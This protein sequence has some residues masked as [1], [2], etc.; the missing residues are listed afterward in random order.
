MNTK[1]VIMINTN[2][3]R[4]YFI[5]YY[6][7]SVMLVFTLFGNIKWLTY[8]KLMTNGTVANAIITT[9]ACSNSQTFSYRFNVGEKSFV[10]SGGDGYGNQPC[11][12][13]KPGDAAMIFYLSSAPET[14]IPG[15]PAARMISEFS[16]IALVAF[17]VPIL[18]LLL[19]F[20]AFKLWRNKKET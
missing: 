10:G 8:L 3:R 13:L 19:F 18:A 15:D 4:I 6:I 17:F 16:A 5:S 14:N 7:I 20:T 12:S 9:T 2:S 1:K 11:S